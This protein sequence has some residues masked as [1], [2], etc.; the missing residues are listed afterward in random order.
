MIPNSTRPISMSRMKISEVFEPCSTLQD[1]CPY[2]SVYDVKLNIPLGKNMLHS[3]QHEGISPQHKWI[4]RYFHYGVDALCGQGA[5]FIEDA[6]LVY[7]EATIIG[8]CTGVRK[9]RNNSSAPIN[10]HVS[11][12]RS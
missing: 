12:G 6:D 10:N 11:C 1:D 9:K 4:D 3:G 2:K 7:L 8:L 5:F